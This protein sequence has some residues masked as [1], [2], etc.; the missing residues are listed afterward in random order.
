MKRLAI[1]T[2]V[3]AAA[4]PARAETQVTPQMLSQ[5]L[6]SKGIECRAPARVF[7]HGDLKLRGK[8]GRVWSIECSTGLKYAVAQERDARGTVW[9]LR[10]DNVEKYTQYRC[11]TTASK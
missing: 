5:Y 10:C 7:A 11:F 8:L 6:D 9:Y 2:L 1:L 3:T 4:M